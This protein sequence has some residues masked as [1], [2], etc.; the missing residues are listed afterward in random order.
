MVSSWKDSDT[1]YNRS[2]KEITWA[3]LQDVS[4]LVQA[5]V[6]VHAYT[7]VRSTGGGADAE[8]GMALALKKP[9]VI[10]GQKSNIFHWLPQVGKVQ[11][12]PELVKWLNDVKAQ[13]KLEKQ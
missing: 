10:L 12:I 8:L 1:G 9:V 5:D 2:D 6:L 11:G 3:A 13:L 4:D 7:Q